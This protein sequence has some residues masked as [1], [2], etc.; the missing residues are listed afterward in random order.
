MFKLALR[1]LLKLAER[2]SWCSWASLSFTPED[3]RSRAT[4]DCLKLCAW[5]GLVGAKPSLD[6]PDF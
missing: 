6:H 2:S 1:V 5:E 3:V 4:G